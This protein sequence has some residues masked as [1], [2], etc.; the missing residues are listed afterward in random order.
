MIIIIDKINLY[1][2]KILENLMSNQYLILLCLLISSIAWPDVNSESTNNGGRYTFSW[3][4]DDNDLLK[5]RG[6]TTTGPEIT[7]DNET[8][9][10]WETLQNISSSGIKKDR[11]A[12]LAMAG[13]YRVSFDFIETIGFK[14]NYKPQRPY[15]SWG[16]EYVYVVEDEPDFISLQHILVMFINMN[17]ELIG[18]IVIKHWRQDWQYENEN[19]Y[20]YQGNNQWGTRKMQ[21]NEVKESWS[22]AVYQVDDSPRYHS[23]GKWI[24]EGNYSSWESD[25]TWRPLPRREFSVRDDYQVLE[26]TNR[27][28]ITPTGWIQEE[29]NLKLVLDSNGKPNQS[30]PYVG[31]EIG[32]ARYERIKNY[33]FSGGDTYWLNTGKFWSNVRIAWQNIFDLHTKIKLKKTINEKQLFEYMLEYADEINSGSR[34]Y[35]DNSAKDFINDTLILFLAIE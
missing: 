9:V 21:P 32:I 31:R 11:A 29:D 18:P 26:G 15:Q 12:I 33:D 6:G 7:L 1:S 3:Q 24:H 30:A 2:P 17:E 8:S 34:K 22:Q 19:L 20:E 16:T 23:F 27:H 10:N 4:F 5:P 13:P 14:P 35:N 25:T 28:T